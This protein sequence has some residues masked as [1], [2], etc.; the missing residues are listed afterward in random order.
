VD[1]VGDER[2]IGQGFGHRL[3]GPGGQAQR[4]VY[5]SDWMIDRGKRARAMSAD[6]ERA[7]HDRPSARRPT[8]KRKLG[9]MMAVAATAL[10]GACDKKAEVAGEPTKVADPATLATVTTPVEASKPT[11]IA[12]EPAKLAGAQVAAANEHAGCA[13]MANAAGSDEA[14][15]PFPE[16]KGAMQGCGANAGVE[17]TKTVTGVH[18]GGAFALG[19]AKPLGQVLASATDGQ[20]LNVR[21]SGQI[22]KVCQKMGCW[23]VVRDGTTEARVVMKDHAFTIP[24]DSKGKPAQVEG[25]LK[26]KVFTEAQ[27]KHLAEDGGADPSKVTGETKEFILTATAVEIGG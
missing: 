7:D 2:R 5:N 14:N 8:M 18:F 11:T 10:V 9:F 25:L 24:V 27:A 22:D 16:E 26:V 20:E 1:E 15:C 6:R 12:A 23:M 3:I 21:V 13:G 4:D 19:E 17:P